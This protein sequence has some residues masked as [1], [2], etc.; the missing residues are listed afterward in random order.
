M[1]VNVSGR[2]LQD[3]QFPDQVIEVLRTFE[4]D[5]GWLEL[6]I[7]ESS[8]MTSMEIAMKTM[9]FLGER[10]IRFSID[11]FGVGYSSLSYLKRLPISS[12]K[13]D[14]SFVKDMLASEDSTAIVRSIVDLAHNLGMEVIAEGVENQETLDR[15]VAMR[16]D[17]AQGYY[18]GTPVSP[19]ELDRWLRESPWGMPR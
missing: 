1:A 19:G 13:I 9:M 15:L 2:N 6:E 17:A 4:M 18:I 12:I 5:P 3:P 16:C 11:D 8:I 10:G 14:R 7:T